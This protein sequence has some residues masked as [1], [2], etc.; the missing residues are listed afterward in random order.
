MPVVDGTALRNRV[1]PWTNQLRWLPGDG[2]VEIGSDGAAYRRG[3]QE[4]PCMTEFWW[5][6]LNLLAWGF[7]LKAILDLRAELAP[8]GNGDRAGRHP[9]K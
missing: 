4:K 7:G 1:G 2:D 5:S 8:R 9:V 6:L 3:V